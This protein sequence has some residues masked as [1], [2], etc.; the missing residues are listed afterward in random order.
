MS[1]A[2]ERAIEQL[3]AL[4]RA[5]HGGAARQELDGFLRRIHSGQPLTL[6][7]YSRAGEILAGLAEA[8][9]GQR[10]ELANAQPHR[11]AVERIPYDADHL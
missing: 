10:R 4:T 2:A 5:A 8:H 3:D 6:A 1:R 9:C 7:E 11:E